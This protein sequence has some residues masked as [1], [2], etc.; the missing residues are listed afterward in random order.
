MVVPVSAVAL[1]SDMVSVSVSAVA[2]VSV[3]VSDVASA[4]VLD[5]AVVFV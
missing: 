1:A 5:V 2:L 3:S 4:L